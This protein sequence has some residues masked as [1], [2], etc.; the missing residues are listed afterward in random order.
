MKKFILSLSFFIIFPLLTTVDAFALR[1][2]SNIVD[3]GDTK[4][5]VLRKCGEPTFQEQWE[6][7]DLITHDTEIDRLGE[8]RIRK[9]IV[10]VDEW[11]YNFGPTRFVY[12]LTFKKGRLV[13]IQTGEKGF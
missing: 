3:I 10:P 4:L 1:C 6:E 9:V 5:D 12:I 8:H 7:E 2:G 11:T 13:D